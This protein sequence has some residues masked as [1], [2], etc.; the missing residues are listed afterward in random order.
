[1]ETSHLGLQQTLQPPN[2]FVH[3]FPYVKQIHL[4]PKRNYPGSHSVTEAG[5]SLASAGDTL[6]FPFN[7]DVT[8][9]GPIEG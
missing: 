6:S 8:P 4:F 1:M 9:Y 5:Q 7:G 2:I 3:F